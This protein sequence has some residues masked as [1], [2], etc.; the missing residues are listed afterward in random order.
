MAK[1]ILI[2]QLALPF[3][4]I[5]SWTTLY[6][7]YIQSG[8]HKIDYIVC[9][10]PEY[11]FKGI[12]Y[13][14]VKPNLVTKFYRKYTKKRYLAY[15]NAL[16]EII[17]TDEKYIIQIVDNF[18]IIPHI[19]ELLERKKI[20]EK[21]YIQFFY[22]GFIPFLDKV[23]GE[24]FFNSINEMVFLTHDSYQVHK[25]FYNAISCK[26]NVLPNGIDTQKFFAISSSEKQSN[27]ENL[28]NNNR[29]IFIW[30]AQDRPKKGLHIVLEAWK[31]INVTHKQ[32]ELWIIGCPEKQKQKG[33]TYM[34][35]LPNDEIP[36]YMQLADVYL[37]ST[38]FQEG[39]PLSL[40]EALHCGCY[41]IASN[42]G[43]NAEVLQYGK[44]G[45][46]IEN[47]HF[48]GEWVEAIENYLANTEVKQHFPSNLYTI[49]S[50]NNNMNIIITNAK[51]CV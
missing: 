17:D 34:G 5:G 1:V 46:L 43:G 37:F 18:Y 39:F 22:H 20:R 44:W 51:F 8:N 45:K 47:P 27:K 12:K 10:K 48:V 38:L 15:I 28:T 23:N 31:K 24:S 21:C 49:E 30:C 2:S 3:S 4:G 35:R 32:C 19:V 16:D 36:K 40:T 42:L 29:S 50:W 6:K 9:E 13:S 33:V 41:C 11:E 7:N 25:I 14:I 26:V